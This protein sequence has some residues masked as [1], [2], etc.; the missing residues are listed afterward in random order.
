MPIARI[1]GQGLAGI[2]VSVSLLWACFVGERV[3][4]NRS[5]AQRAQVI[6][7]LRQ[8]QLMYRTQPA[9]AP[10]PLPRPAPPTVG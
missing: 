10:M 8:M 7:D 4:L 1:T 2:A 5:Y 6:R 3:V 9:S